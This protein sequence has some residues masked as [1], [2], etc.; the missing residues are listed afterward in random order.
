M[1]LFEVLKLLNANSPP[2]Q[3]QNR[4]NPSFSNYPFEAFAQN[5]ISGQSNSNP[6]ANLINGENN[7]LPL[8]MSMLGKGG[9]V[10]KIFSQ[11]NQKKEEVKKE[12]TS[13]KDEILL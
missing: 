7:I 13:P 4:N 5:N 9:D 12:S 3:E 6:F 11:N 1:N 2:H 8:L 10:S